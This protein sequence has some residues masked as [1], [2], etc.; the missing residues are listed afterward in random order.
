MTWFTL[1]VC[2]S[3]SGWKAVL[4]FNSVPTA[5]NNPFQNLEVNLGKPQVIYRETISASVKAE[6]I[7]EKEI[8]E[9]KH[10]GQVRL[11]LEPKVRG[12]GIEFSHTIREDTILEKFI[13][14]VEEGVREATL[15]GVV[16]GY[17]VVDVKV[18]LIEINFREKDSRELAYKI[19]ASMAV[20]EGCEQAGPVL[21]E[22]F[23][24]IEV[25]VP[26]E[27]MGEVISDLNARKGKLGNI[28][29]KGKVSLVHAQVPLKQMFGY[30]TSLRSATQGRGTFTMQF[31]HYDQAG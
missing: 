21:L 28:T 8:E 23:M 25:V 9:V 7:F 22:P 2:P 20:K 27:F 29:P 5:S 12:E 26:E 17:P 14:A 15:S 1:S 31:S 16:A 4:R 10:F 30:S 6:G 19:A 11:H 13:P 18:T 3:V 24:S